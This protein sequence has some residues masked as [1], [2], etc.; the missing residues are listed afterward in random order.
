MFNMLSYDSDQANRLELTSTSTIAIYSFPTTRRDDVELKR[1]NSL[2]PSY[3]AFLHNYARHSRHMR[4]LRWVRGVP[5][6]DS[7]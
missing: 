7:S 5:R 3:I 6:W 4:N 2:V 1:V